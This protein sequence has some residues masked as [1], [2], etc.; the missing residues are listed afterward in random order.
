M[1]RSSVIIALEIC[2]IAA[3][4][5]SWSF[6]RPNSRQ[7]TVGNASEHFI[8]WVDLLAYLGAR[9]GGDF[10]HYQASD[11]TEAAE[12]LQNGVTVE[13]LTKNMTSFAYYREAYG[14]VL[15]GMVGLYEIEIPKSEAP[16]FALADAQIQEGDPAANTSYATTPPTTTGTDTIDSASQASPETS[17]SSN[18]QTSL[19]PPAPT[20]SDP[21]A[22][23]LTPSGEEKVWVTKYGLKAFL[24][25]AKNFP[26]SHYDDFGVSRSYGYRRRHL[27]HDMMGQTGTPVIA[28]ESG[29]VEALG[30]NQYGGWRIGIR[31][32]DGKRYYYYAHLRK[33]YP[34][35]SN[36]K[37][38]SLVT[39]GD[40]IGYLGHTGY[41]STENTNNI[42]EPH[43]HF[44]LQ[45]IFDE[46]QKEG[47]NEIWI[48]CY[49]LIR[50]L[51]INRSETVKKDGTKEWTR[52]YEMKDSSLEQFSTQ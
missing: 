15:D 13:E 14:A 5:V 16:A 2:A 20:L 17:A 36:L 27:G 23:P 46:S 3:L 32:F 22:V 34:Y 31:S 7:V 10:S 50:F 11:M 25:L 29:R 9:Y 42:A 37:E 19:E 49:E 33:D 41:S 26:Y 51:A 21:D 47:N 38:G 18:T 28:V 40:V 6:Q 30:W 43:L 8:H 24:P 12:Q 52:V 48:D 44:G 1:K 45:L 35:Q 4:F 39:A